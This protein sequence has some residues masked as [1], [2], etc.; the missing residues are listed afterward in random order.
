MPN[1]TELLIAGGVIGIIGVGGYFAVNDIICETRAGDVRDFLANK[2]TIRLQLKEDI[3]RVAKEYCLEAKCDKETLTAV[4][5]DTV[6]IYVELRKNNGFVDNFASVEKIIN[7]LSGASEDKDSL[8]D[9]GKATDRLVRFM[10]HYTT[11]EIKTVID[12][13]DSLYDYKSDTAGEFAVAAEET[14]NACTKAKCEIGKL[15]G[16]IENL[17]KN[18]W[19]IK[20]KDLDVY[21]QVIHTSGKKLQ[22]ELSVE[23]HSML[24]PYLIPGFVPEKADVPEAELP[25]EAAPFAEAYVPIALQQYAENPSAYKKV[26]ISAYPVSQAM[27]ELTNSY[28]FSITDDGF[29][30]DCLDNGL[31]NENLFL[32]NDINAVLRHNE[33]FADQGKVTVFGT[34]EDN[35]LNIDEVEVN[36]KR[37]KL[38]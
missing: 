38:K 23:K 22:G 37:R 29:S 9:L 3:R 12:E 13:L 16:W 15:G 24:I 2:D 17:E 26:E 14:L 31:T 25:A 18:P 21:V 6:D 8:E 4:T 30:L 27:L 19:Q 36:G 28:A 5:T 11:E 33:K 32:F 34:I 10:A 7:Q 20:E 35:V 1:L